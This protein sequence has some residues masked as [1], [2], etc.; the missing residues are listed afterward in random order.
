MFT[1]V[2]LF[3]LES[4]NR[5]ILENAVGYY[6]LNQVVI[7]IAPAIPDVISLLEQIDIN[8]DTWYTIIKLENVFFSIPVTKDH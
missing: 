7:P 6:K 8:P 4:W 3:Y 5:Q 1:T 2:P